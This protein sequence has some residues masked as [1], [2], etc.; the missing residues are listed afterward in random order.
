MAVAWIG[1]E[2]MLAEATGAA[3]GKEAQANP[4]NS[5]KTIIHIIT[6]IKLN[7]CLQ[8]LHHQFY[9]NYILLL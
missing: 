6:I 4:Y 1:Q 5:L 3:I 7:C 2:A 9:I 8:I